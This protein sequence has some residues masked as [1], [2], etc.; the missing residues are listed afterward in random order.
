V[1]V[2][3]AYAGARIAARLERQPEEAVWAHLATARTVAAYLTAARR[4][5]VAPWVATLASTATVHEIERTVRAEAQGAVREVAGWVV[6]EW[7]PAVAWLRHLMVLELLPALVAG[8]VAWA[9]EDPTLAPYAGG[10]VD[11]APLALGRLLAAVGGGGSALGAWLDGWR[12]LWPD[13]SPAVVADR[14]HRLGSPTLPAGPEAG[15]V[16]TALL[17]LVHRQP[18][19]P[20]APLAYLVLVILDLARLRG[21]LVARAFFEGGEP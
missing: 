5:P 21:G 2:R 15:A 17:R 7:R 12:A 8:E 10:E 14:L 6:A 16:R 4:S 13:P 3:L 1:R 9:A 11:R 18:A 20:V 19:E